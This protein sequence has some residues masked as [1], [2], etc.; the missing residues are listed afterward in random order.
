MSTLP[1]PA[2]LPPPPIVESAP[3]RRPRWVS[4]FLWGALACSLLGASAAVRRIQERQHRDDAKYIETCPFP[5]QQIPPTL[6]AWKLSSEGEQ[7]I[8]KDTMRITGGTD[9]ILRNYVNDL[10]GVRLVVLLLFGPAEPVLPHTPEACYPA[11]GFGGAEDP[12]IRQLEYSEPGS[13]ADAPKKLASFRTAVYQKPGLRVLREG[14]F[15]SFRLNGVWSPDVA[16]GKKF[17]RRNPGVFKLQIQR[18]M[19]DKERRSENTLINPAKPDLGKDFV[20]PIEDFLMS[21]IPEVESRI[22]KSTSQ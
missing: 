12:M 8:D 15:Y 5:L 22:A 11:N 19:A 21:L 16:A 3:L 2:D 10:T 4:T 6:G 14:V 18:L 17:P 9:H 13:P 7:K 20:D 1:E